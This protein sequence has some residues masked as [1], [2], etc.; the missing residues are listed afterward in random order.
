MAA[1]YSRDLAKK[2][3]AARRVIM[4]Q[5]FWTGGSP[6][7]GYRREV[8]DRQGRPCEAAD[9]SVWR[10]RQGVHTRLVLG[11]D[12]EVQTVRRVFQQYLRPKATFGTI[13]RWLNAQ[14]IS[15]GVGGPWMSAR[16][17]HLLQNEIYV[18]R[19]VARHR[20]REIGS[21]T[22]R[23]MPREDWIVVED[24]APAIVS[25]KVFNAVQRKRARQAQPISDTE[26]LEDARRVAR[27]QGTLSQ[28]ILNR[29]SQWGASVYGRRFGGMRGLRSL[30]GVAAP[31]Q[32][33]RYEAFLG[34]ANEARR[35]HES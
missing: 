26:L 4:A 5:G 19:L 7:Y 29:H 24:A 17:G 6:A 34:Q 32:C 27:E 9:L 13:A 14:N 35:L 16:V 22:R 30:L 11:P 21:G 25:K 20:P 28:G 2:V 33:W 23:L 8:V 3:T 1:E 18:G 15:N 31:R 12:C 10:K